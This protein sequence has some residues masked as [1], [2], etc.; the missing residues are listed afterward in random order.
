[1]PR[2]SPMSVKSAVYIA[3]R[4]RLVSSNLAD[5]DFAAMISKELGASV[6]G[7]MISY[8]RMVLKII[9]F[10]T[11]RSIARREAEVVALR[12]RAETDRANTAKGLKKG[13]LR[14]TVDSDISEVQEFIR[15]YTRQSREHLEDR[16]AE[17]CRVFDVATR[18]IW[19]KFDEDEKLV[20]KNAE[21][22]RIL[23]GRVTRLELQARAAAGTLP[24]GWKI[25][26]DAGNEIERVEVQSS[27]P[28]NGTGAHR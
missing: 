9:P 22:L 14:T 12:E 11:R 21:R 3:V 28:A 15:T 16:L 27:P 5:K 17:R 24:N 4:D 19:S 13:A 6:T 1:M 18:N 8:Y 26:D 7:H 10:Q 25:V 2:Q 23:E 20:T